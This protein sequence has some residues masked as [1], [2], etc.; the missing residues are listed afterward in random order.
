MTAF[1]DRDRAEALWEEG[2]RYRLSRPYP[3]DLEAE[4]RFHTRGVAEAAEKI[5]ACVPGLVPEKAFVFGLLHDY[6]KRVN[7]S[8]ENKFHGQEGYEQMMK[9]G[10]P[11]IARICL[12]HTFPDKDFNPEQYSFPPQW[13]DW[14]RCHLAP[15]VYDDYDLLIAFC[16]KL[17]EA[18]TMVSIE[19]R[20][21]AIVR[22]YGLNDRQR[23][24]LYNQSM[25]LKHYFD[26]KTGRDVYEI[27]G[28]EK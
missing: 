15:L 20:V 24:L 5:A 13:F 2:I 14:I 22:R 21:A 23:D 11:E 8:R 26:A 3:F 27:L 1:P 18:C 12:T 17:F 6:G 9:L 28:L 10:Y 25:K 4:Y 19:E 16:D 7:Q